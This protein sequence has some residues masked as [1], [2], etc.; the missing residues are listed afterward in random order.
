[1]DLRN[2]LLKRIEKKQ[3]EIREYEDRIREATAYVQGLQDTLK[4]IPKDDEF[5]NQE[6]SLR[7]GSNV[8]K[9]RDALKAAG[10]P[11]HITDIL[12]AIGQPIDK[13]HR[14][15]LGG[16]IASYARKG[17]IFTKTAPN[18]FGLSEFESKTDDLT[19]VIDPSGGVTRVQTNTIG[20]VASTTS[21]TK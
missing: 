11:L 1:M 18:T 13:K 4:L 12:K 3:A 14:L 9:A 15:A 17:A 2:E 10:K 5:G 8:G 6:I 16:S 20:R 21:L 19:L 7:H